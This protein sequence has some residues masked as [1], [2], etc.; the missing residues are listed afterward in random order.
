MTPILTHPWFVPLA[1]SAILVAGFPLAVGYLVLLERKL[2][3]DIQVRYGPM[4]VGPHGLLQPLA[5]AVKLALKEDTTPQDSDQPLFWAAP[6]LTFLAAFLALAIVPWTPALRV[7][8]LNAGVLLLTGFG[9]LGIFGIILAGWAANSHYP[10]LGAL[11]AS[12][13]LVSYE[14]PLSFALLAPVML[15]GTLN[16]ERLVQAQADQG[17]WFLFAN[18]GLMIPA[19]FIFLICVTAESNRPPFDLP[20]AESELVSGYHT[21]YSGFR[22]ALLMLAEYTNMVVVAALTVIAFLGGWL[23]PFQSLPWIRPLTMLV[24][25]AA[26]LAIAAI[27]I[28]RLSLR[29]SGWRR[30][31]LRA[32]TAAFFLCSAVVAIPPI[33]PW[34]APLFWFLLKLF[35]LIYLLIWA[36]GTF[37]RLRYDQLMD[38]SWKRLTPLALAILTLNLIAAA[39]H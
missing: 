3:A 39:I 13:Q 32:V 6:V 38:L 2:L 21:E 20:E 25:P 18:F 16:L 33:N 19:F 26:L 29:Q 12:A 1:L 30:W 35:A 15:A 11:R 24:L 9:A 28:A 37:P 34:L 17:V 5:D 10:L 22:F 23:A 36:R 8:N 4:R 31:I 14:V 27:G 7:V